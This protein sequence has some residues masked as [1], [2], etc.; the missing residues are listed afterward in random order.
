MSGTREDLER[1]VER[2]EAEA[3][4]HGTPVDGGNDI[5]PARWLNAPHIVVEQ[6]HARPDRPT[7]DDLWYA[8]HDGWVGEH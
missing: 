2:A 8:L 4:R 7:G 3:D 5:I 6:V 1:L